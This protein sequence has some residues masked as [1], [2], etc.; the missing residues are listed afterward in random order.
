MFSLLGLWPI[1]YSL[2]ARK[3]SYPELKG[4][5]GVLML[6]IEKRTVHAGGCKHAGASFMSVK[7]LKSMKL[8]SHI[9]TYL[10][11]RV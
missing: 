2:L 1:E 11:S 8:Y 6:E 9:A 4:L 10:Q 5:L 7:G 3:V